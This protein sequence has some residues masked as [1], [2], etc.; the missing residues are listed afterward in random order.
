MSKWGISAKIET[1]EES[2]GNARNK[3]RN[4]RNDGLFSQ[5]YQSQEVPQTEALG[6]KKNEQNTVKTV[7]KYQIAQH[8][9]EWSHRGERE[10]NM[11]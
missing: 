5:A 7:G 1:T 9:N 3:K 10:K 11:Q 6:I 2:S 4:A 8:R